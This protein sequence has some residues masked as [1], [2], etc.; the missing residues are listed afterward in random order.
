MCD[1]LLAAAGMGDLGVQFGVS[2]PEWA[3]ASGVRLL[4]Q[5]AQRLTAAGWKI[6]NVSVQLISDTPRLAERRTEAQALL[7]ETIGAPVG[8]SATTTDGL[9]F[10]GRG[11]GRAAVASALVAGISA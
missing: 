11:D 8:L 1:A 5:T 6:G 3:D 7:S 9:G 2:D 4:A 10:I